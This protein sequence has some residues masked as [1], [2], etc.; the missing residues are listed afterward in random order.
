MLLLLHAIFF[1][2]E[3]L[4]FHLETDNNILPYILSSPYFPSFKLDGV[5][6]TLKID[7]EISLDKN[8][9]LADLSVSIRHSLTRMRA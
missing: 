8:Y 4:T 2:I 1:S 6:C 5:Q 7:C 9:C 3:L